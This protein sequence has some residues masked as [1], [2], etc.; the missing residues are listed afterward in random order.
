[1]SF[2][3]VDT[4]IEALVAQGFTRRM[5]QEYLDVLARED[6]SPL[7]EGDF[8]AWAH[9]RGFSAESASAYELTDAN[10]SDYLSDYDYARV[11]PLNGWQRVWVNDKLTLKYLLAGTPWGTLLPKYYFYAGVHG[12]VP[13]MDARARGTRDGFLGTLREVGELACKPCNG[14]HAI[15]FN[16]LGYEGGTYL[17]NNREADADA[18]WR[19][20]RDH[21][22]DIYTEFLHAGGGLERMSPVVHT[23]RVLTVNPTATDP[24]LAACY[25]RLAT[26]VGGD[27]SKPNYRPPE[28]AGV[29]SLNLRLDM[30]DGSFDDGRLVYGN[31]VVHSN[32]HPDTGV[33]CT[34]TIDCWPQ[35]REL[36]EG[37]ALYLGLVEYMG[38]D[39][40]VTPEGP[41]LLEI[42]S[43]SGCKYL[44][45]FRPFM[46]DAYLGDYFRAK[47]DAL[48]A[49]DEA[50]RE[51]RGAIRR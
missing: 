51:A 2:H 35:V 23:L 14:E 19:F 17:I 40:C 5:G 11:W 18:V 7:F 24:V 3:T 43:H 50:G 30:D 45:L 42:N 20:V 9:S 27:D 46:A 10:A 47:L 21:P 36:C 8:R 38:L 22:N 12:P 1:M 41:R 33:P 34:G 26:G 31:H 44:Q 28:Q 29:C 32:L 39:V 6:A 49:L 48:D 16:K 4:T 37:L 15:G 13:L 25:L